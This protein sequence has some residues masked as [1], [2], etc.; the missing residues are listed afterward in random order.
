MKVKAGYQDSDEFNMNAYYV[1]GRSSCA[2]MVPKSHALGG[3][4]PVN[5]ETVLSVL[6]SSEFRKKQIIHHPHI[7]L[8]MT[9][10]Y[11][12]SHGVV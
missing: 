12:A 3:H 4:Q 11:T 1:R 5:G 9:T 7:S 6:L 10:G 2:S 8:V